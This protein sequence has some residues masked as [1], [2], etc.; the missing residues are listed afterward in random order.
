MTPAFSNS[1]YL[2]SG[3][4]FCDGVMQA[5]LCNA[6]PPRGIS[7]RQLSLRIGP[8]A[9]SD[10]RTLQRRHGISA[11]K[12]LVTA[13]RHAGIAHSLGA[14]RIDLLYVWRGL[15]GRA[16]LGAM[17]AGSQGI[18][19]VYF[20]GGA[21]PGYFQIDM[22]GVNARA[23]IPRDPRFFS[24]WRETWT[25]PLLDWRSL[26]GTISA[27]KP[28]R[29][30]VAQEP[31]GDWSAEG[32]FL[33]CPFQ[34]NAAGETLPDGGWVADPADLVA[35]LALASHALPAGW[36]LRLKPHPN[37]RGDLTD[38]V[39]RHPDARLVLDRDTSSL[40][41]LRASRGVV[42]V[43]S[44]MGLQ[45]FFDDKP[46]I[47]LGESYFSGSGRTQ[48]AG[49]VQELTDFL[50]RADRL[51]FVASARDDLMTFLFNDFFVPEERLRA[52]DF[53]VAALV[54]RHARHRAILAAL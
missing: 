1:A 29:N 13:A 32:P 9:I 46:V 2:E 4:P 25:G 5:L 30:L 28:R 23:S 26:R 6:R 20:E 48:S 45:A 12:T 53:D 10:A 19:C 34:M 50:G 22:Q 42:T 41:Q 18:A 11:A 16:E 24:R 37:A 47:V 43:N 17:A 27:A 15:M 40:D 35:A 38:L 54:G 8:A 31:R 14:G 51:D 33:F 7:P 3:D 44:A 49:N 36:H 21:L 52:G 39:A